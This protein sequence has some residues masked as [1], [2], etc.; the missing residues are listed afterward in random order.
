M[1]QPDLPDLMIEIDELRQAVLAEA[2]SFMSNWQGLLGASPYAPSA[3]NLAQYLA[4]RH[5]DLRG[6]QRRLALAGLSSLGRAEAHVMPTLNAVKSIL[7]R[8]SGKKST[9][10]VSDEEFLFGEQRIT[11]EAEA[12]LGALTPQSTVRLMVTLPT[13]ASED[14]NFLVQLAKLGVESVRINT[15]HDDEKVWADMIAHVDWAAQVTGRR[16][17]VMMD[18]PGPKIRSGKPREGKDGARVLIGDSMALVR[19]KLLKQSPT[20]LAAVECLSPEALSLAQVGHRVL[21]DDG[22]LCTTVQACHDWGVVLQVDAGPDEKGYKL[23]AEKGIAFPDTD[24]VVPAL[25]PEDRKILRFAAKHADAIEYSFV[26]RPEDILDLQAALAEIRPDD[27]QE[28]GLVLK[29]ETRLAVANLPEMIVCAAARQPTAVMIARGDLAVEIGF[30]RVAEMQEEILWLCEAAHV[31]VVWATQVLESFLKT[32][33]PSRGEMT[34]A[35]MA[36]RAEC[37]MLN[38]GP[39]LFEGIVM[40]DRLLDRMT[41]HMSKKSH[42]L[43]PLQSW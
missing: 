11:A 39:H 22:K 29:I 41:A 10:L 5:H 4:L 30:A 3:R 17:K 27:W 2:D 37:V 38:K 7:A 28:L 20:K 18:L 16:M 21:I 1:S 40:L 26:Q 36:A 6:L 13:E 12:I 24:L 25:T 23:K 32:G 9:A 19:P 43:R 35:A 34:D 8:A 15:A 14:T 31:P 33:V 42:L